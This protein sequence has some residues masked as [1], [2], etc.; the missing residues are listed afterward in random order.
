MAMRSYHQPR[1]R[2]HWPEL[3]LNLW[4]LIVLGGSAVCLGIFS[5]F[6]VVQSQLGLGIPWYPSIPPAHPQGT[7]PSEWM[8]DAW[9][10]ADN[11]TGS[12]P[13]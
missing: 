13:T 2:Y 10:N 12:F 8:D 7:G 11:Q 1:R 4:I 3:Q 6:M 5:W 9:M